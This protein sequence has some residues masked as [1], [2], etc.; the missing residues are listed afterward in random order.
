MLAA[1]VFQRYFPDK[2]SL[3]RKVCS[4]FISRTNSI[5]KQKVSI[6]RFWSSTKWRELC[7]VCKHSTQRREPVR[8]GTTGSQ[9]DR[10]PWV[11][12]NSLV[13]MYKNHMP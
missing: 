1:D 9:R 4:P 8:P 10:S 7:N 3:A 5:S 12:I 6:L 11:I 2:K 13:F